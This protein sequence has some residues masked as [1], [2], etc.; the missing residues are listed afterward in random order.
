MADIG[1]PTARYSV[2]DTMAAVEAAIAESDGQVVIKADGLAAGKGVVVCSSARRGQRRRARVLVNGRFGTAGGR[3]VVE[4]R[5]AAP[6]ISLLALCDGERV[7]PLA[8]AATSSPPTTA[9]KAP[10]TGGMGCMS[11]LAGCRRRVDRA[12]PGHRAPTGR[13]RDGPP[14]A[15]RSAAVSTPG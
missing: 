12:D 9:T 2:C 4:E 3:V 11:P 15:S 6:E 10:N 14:R 7:L 8:P 13:V 5:M 1:V